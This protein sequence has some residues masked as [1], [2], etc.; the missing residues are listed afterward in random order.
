MITAADFRLNRLACGLLTAEEI[1][2]LAREAEETEEG[3]ML[4]ATFAS[5]PSAYPRLAS[6]KA[7]ATAE[8]GIG[9]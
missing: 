7:H 2:E 8:G 4:L 1:A 3:T 9:S 5:A 6:W